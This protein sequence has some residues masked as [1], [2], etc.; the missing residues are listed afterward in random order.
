MRKFWPGAACALL[1][2]AAWAQ[3][4][5]KSK[6]VAQV[7]PPPQQAQQQKQMRTISLPNG[8]WIR[9]EAEPGDDQ[10]PP[11]EVIVMHMEAPPPPAT[12]QAEEQPP[13]HV[14][15]PLRAD[16][17]TPLRG[18]LVQ[19]LLELRGIVVDPQMALWLER[20]QN[21]GSTSVTNLNI[22][23]E[24]ALLDAVRTDSVAY[25]MAQDLSQC[26]AAQRR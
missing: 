9:Y 11:G 16:P 21:L 13:A 1:A 22:P 24:P 4:T 14:M 8:G 15:R 7:T 6:T 26:E 17:C 23:N 10:E 3:G 20:N 12:G 5:S 19:R 25:G 18:K 2:S